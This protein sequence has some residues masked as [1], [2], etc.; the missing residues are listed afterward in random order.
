MANENS[1][2][3]RRDFLIGLGKAAGIS[4]GL[5]ISGCVL[6]SM[7][8][9]GG[10]ATGHLAQPAQP[11]YDRPRGPARAID[12]HHHYFPA[13]LV[14]EIKKHGRALGIEYLP[15]RN[16]R[17]SP[18]SFSFAGGSRLS[19]E[20]ALADVDKRFEIMGKGRVAMA[21]V[22]VQTSAQG[23]QLGGERGAAWAR[24]YNEA[25]HNLVKRHPNRFVGMA[26]VPLQDPPR[27]AQVLEHAIRDLKFSGVTIASNVNGKYFDSK[28]FDPFWKKAEELDVLVIMHPDNVLG[29]EKMGA[30]GLRTVCGNPADTTLSVGFMI[31]SGVFDRFPK[32]KLGLLHGGGFFPYH[33]GRFDQ[34]FI[35]GG[36]ASRIP[37]SQPPSR[38]L[39][40]LYF[41]N[42]VYRVETVDYLRR[43]VGT[44]HVMV[45]TDYPYELGDWM[46]VEKIEALNC[47]EA[48]REAMLYGNARTLLKISASQ[49]AIETSPSPR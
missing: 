27:A 38:Y 48:E 34:R 37:A 4:S 3:S 32:L 41:D 39:K 33:L 25:I 49:Q 11:L 28:E 26:T 17:E 1:A 9:T 42:L 6:P 2:I 10:S 31:Y 13:E 8:Q 19:L 40:N 30:Y 45:G 29:S 46:A 5:F 7:V 24:L 21:S 12:I 15:P 22:E 43:M 35:T 20:P 16:S 18:L 44:E 36:D 23:Y 14:D 47:T